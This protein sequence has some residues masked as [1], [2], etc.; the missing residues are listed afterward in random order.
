MGG[1]LVGASTPSLRGRGRGEAVGG[2]AFGARPLSNVKITGLLRL[3]SNF[4]YFCI[5]NDET[6]TLH[7]TL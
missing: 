2:G 4:P 6:G 1:G 7:L 3:I 5:M